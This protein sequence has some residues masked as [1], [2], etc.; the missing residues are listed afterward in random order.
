MKRFV[1]DLVVTSDE[2]VYTLEFI[3]FNPNGKTN[4]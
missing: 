4:Y 3:Q 2:A 1:N